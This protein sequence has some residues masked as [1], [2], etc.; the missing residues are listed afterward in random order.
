MKLIFDDFV[1]IKRSGKIILSSPHAKR[2]FREGK[3]KAKEIRT[4]T[5]GKTVAQK[6]GQSC[7][8]RSKFAKNDP[9]YDKKSTYKE[10]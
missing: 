2:Q 4:G 10:Y 8:Y 7:I 9:N 6:T 5:L 3:I 1:I